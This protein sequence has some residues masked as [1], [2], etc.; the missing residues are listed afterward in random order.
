MSVGAAVAAA[1]GADRGATVAAAAVFACDECV[2]RSSCGMTGVAGEWRDRGAADCESDGDG[3]GGGHVAGDG[4]G[5][6]ADCDIDCDGDEHGD[7]DG[8]AGALAAAAAAVGL[9][10]AALAGRRVA[11][12]SCMLLLAA[13]ILSNAL[14]HASGE[15]K[16]SAH[17]GA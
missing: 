4:D 2:A 13:E 10:A 5:D 6:A 9:A 7:G 14:A 8:D 15:R 17:T 12:V 1:A 11:R 16:K 3:G